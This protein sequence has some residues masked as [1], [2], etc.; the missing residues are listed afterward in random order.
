MRRRKVL[1]HRSW[2]LVQDDDPVLMSGQCRVDQL[3]GKDGMRLR[4]DN[5]D[6]PELTA[7]GLVDGQCIRQLQRSITLFAE[8]AAVEVVGVALL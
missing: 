3:P 4:H 7:L 1:Q 5:H 2:A 6:Q 8:V